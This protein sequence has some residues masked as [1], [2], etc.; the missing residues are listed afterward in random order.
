M[1]PLDLYAQL[2]DTMN[3]GDLDRFRSISGHDRM[4]ESVRRM[5]AAFPDV[6]LE[7]EWVMADGD[8]V[9]GWHHQT[10]THLGTW[11][12]LPPTGR[13]IDVRGSVTIEVHDGAVSDF[14]LANDWLG[15]ATQLG[16]ELVLPAGAST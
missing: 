2:L 13:R 7:Q 3:R 1:A 16:V 5:F 6:R 10:G 8:K 4:T 15:I 12:G 9:T 14:W 11:R